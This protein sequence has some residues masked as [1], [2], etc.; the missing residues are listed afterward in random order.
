MKRLSIVFVFM[1]LLAAS[2]CNK[3]PDGKSYAISGEINVESGIIYLQEF[4]NKMFAI[5]DSAVI[6]NGK[7]AFAGTLARPD[8][9][10]LT[11]DREETFSPYYIFLENSPVKVKIDTQNTQSAEITGSSVNDLY[12]AYLQS[13]SEAGDAFRIDTFI[14]AHP[15]SIVSAYVL[16]RD[17]SYR[18]SREEIDANVLRLD[19]SLHDTQYVKVLNELSAVLETVAIGKHAPAFALPDTEGKTVSLSDRLGKGYVLLDFWASWCGPCRR[20][21][22]NI[23]K[24]YNE[25]KDKG[26]DVFSVSLDKEKDAWIKGIA[27]DNLTWTHVSDILFWDS[28]PAKLYGVRA[29]PANFLIDKDGVIVA[30]NLRGEELGKTLSELLQ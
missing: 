24:T 9:F 11:I 3:T 2:A 14:A 25:Y 16:Y 18:L 28:A 8:L 20:E 26:F 17:F 30:R 13:A 4:H 5:I 21:N 27:D 1:V 7:F 6:E 23:V 12:V 10:G 15:S 22:P 29:I 19:A